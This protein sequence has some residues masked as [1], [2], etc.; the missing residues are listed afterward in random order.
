MLLVARPRGDKSGFSTSI[1]LGLCRDEG[2]PRLDGWLALVDAARPK[3]LLGRLAPGSLGSLVVALDPTQLLPAG[4][5]P[6]MWSL[7]GRIFG[8]FSHLGLDVRTQV[9]RRLGKAG[10][11]QMMLLPGEGARTRTAYSFRAR[12]RDAA[13]KLYQDVKRAVTARQEGT[14]RKLAT[15]LEVLEMDSPGFGIFSWRRRF[16]GVD[17][18]FVAAIGDALYLTLD[19]TT[20]EAVLAQTKAPRRQHEALVLKRLQQ[21]GLRDKKVAG[22]FAVD[23]GVLSARLVGDVA[24]GQDS[25]KHDNDTDQRKPPAHSGLFGLHA[26]YFTLE[27]DVIRVEVFSPR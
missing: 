5:G 18:V 15:G 9:I 6:G 3:Q 1:L 12:S 11:V 19:K 7:Q 25:D 22:L 20:M 10:S 16:G 2:R 8:F 24:R 23:L 4:R 14:V 26:G 21:L 27:H 17:T 13:R